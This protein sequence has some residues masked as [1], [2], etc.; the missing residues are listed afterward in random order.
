MD[1]DVKKIAKLANLSLQDEEIEKF[2]QQLSSIL[3]YIKKLNEVNTKN[4]ME[5]SQVTGLEN[6]TRNDAASAGLSQEEAIANAKSV[7]NG[8]FKVPAVLDQ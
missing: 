1:I 3:D 4:V 2:K 6:V 5:T 7:H 8:L